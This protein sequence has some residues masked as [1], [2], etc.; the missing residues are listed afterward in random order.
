MIQ[1]DKFYI[2]RCL[3]GHSDDFRCLVQRYQPALLA[4]LVGQ[5]GSRDHAEEVTQE[6]LVRAYFALEKLK[7]PDSFFSWLFGI[8]KQVVRE[9]QKSDQR[10][11]S[12]EFIHSVSEQTPAPEFSKGYALEKAIAR[13][14]DSY[15]Q[16]ILLRYFTNLSCSQVAEQLDMPLG[17][18]TKTLSRA[19]ALLRKSMSRQEHQGDY[20]VQK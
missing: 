17:T 19:Y 13:L 3:N 14:P 15:R 12:R 1:S 2:E 7:K 5:L 6:A 10:R 20:E 11:R 4:H 9:Q 8:A 18:V 16:V